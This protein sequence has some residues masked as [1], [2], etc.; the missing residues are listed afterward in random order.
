VD[1]AAMHRWFEQ[2]ASAGGWPPVDPQGQL[3]MVDEAATDDAP[4]N[5]SSSTP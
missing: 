1:D 5:H 4:G 3:D 2:R